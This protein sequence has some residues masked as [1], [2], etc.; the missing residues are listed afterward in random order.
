MT[1]V[2]LDHLTIFDT[3]PPELIDIA[4]G[5]GVPLVSLWTQLPLQA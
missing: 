5:L 3:S 2:S 4:A 1:A